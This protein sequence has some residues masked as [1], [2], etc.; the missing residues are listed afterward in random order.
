MNIQEKIL[1]MKCPHCNKKF[2][3]T[4]NTIR[5]PHC[6]IEFDPETVHQI[7]FNLESDIANSKIYSASNK[8]KTG[9]EILSGLGYIIFFLPIMIILIIFLYFLTFS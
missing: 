9:G 1:P 4:F 2:K 3:L 8:L 5:C 6:N 7:F